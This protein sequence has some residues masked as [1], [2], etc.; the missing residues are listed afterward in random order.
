MKIKF[1]VFLPK[2]IIRQRNGGKNIPGGLAL[3][4][5]N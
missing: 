3:G 4:S 1:T 2:E 5:N